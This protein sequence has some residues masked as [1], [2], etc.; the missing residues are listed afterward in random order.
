MAW[1]FS[2]RCKSALK[3]GKIKVSLSQPIRIRLWRCMKDFDEERYMTSETGYNHTEM[4]LSQLEESLKAELGVDEL[5]AF[6]KEGSGTPEPSNLE[7]LILRGS[8]PPYVLDAIELL[9]LDVTPDQ[10][11]VL[12]HAF[13]EIMEESNCGWRMAEGKVFP[14]DSVYIEE[15]IL[16]RSHQLLHEQKFH[17]ALEEF[18]KARTDLVNGDNVGAIQNAN[19]AVESTVKGVLGVERAKPGQLYRMLS[20]AGQIPEYFQG[21]VKDFESN[22]LR[23]VAIIRNEEKGAGH[24]QGPDIHQVPKS[25][26]ELAVN[27]AG[28][29]INFLIKQ[30]LEKRPQTA[31]ADQTQADSSEDTATFQ[32]DNLPF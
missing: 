29:L 17:G 2:K 10:Q 6:P 12:Q 20:E 7:G 19:L 16:R 15:E 21:F 1:L 11:P 13:N 22:I 4:L 8:R 9:Y 23:S 14:V 31:S 27:L 24:G 25:L 5:L 26:A 3:S 28:V 18:N 30:H 32:D